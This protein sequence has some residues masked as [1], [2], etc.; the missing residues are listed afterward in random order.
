MEGLYK[1]EN[2]YFQLVFLKTVEYPSIKIECQG[3]GQTI[4]AFD[5]FE[6]TDQEFEWFNKNHKYWIGKTI[7][8]YAWIKKEIKELEIADGPKK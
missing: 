4:K 7:Y 6:L 1:I 8:V 5:D 2:E 3:D